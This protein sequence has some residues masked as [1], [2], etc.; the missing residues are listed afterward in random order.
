MAVFASKAH[1]RLLLRLPPRQHTAGERH[2]GVFSSIFR[3]PAQLC[4]H[5]V[6]GVRV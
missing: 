2:F 6:V 3:L 4:E 1:V 5:G